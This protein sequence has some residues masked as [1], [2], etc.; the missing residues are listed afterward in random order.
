MVSDWKDLEMKITNE[1][2]KDLADAE[3]K[4]ID[5]MAENS[6]VQ[7]RHKRMRDSHHI[8]V[9]TWS[10]RCAGFNYSPYHICS[11]LIRLYGK[12]HPLKGN[13]VRQHAPP[14]LWIADQH[15]ETQR[16]HH[17]PSDG[18]RQVEQP[19]TLTQLGINPADLWND[20]ERT[21][22]NEYSRLE[23]KKR[24]YQE[25]AAVVRNIADYMEDEV[26]HGGERLRRLPPPNLNGLKQLMRLM[27]NARVLDRCRK[28]CKTW[29]TERVG[30]NQF[31][32]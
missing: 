19:A 31:R 6:P 3:A 2:D 22:E 15:D 28:R 11:H 7:Q 18:P 17:I 14:L 30:G 32:G 4:S 8:N 10:C 21:D 24:K 29:G 23:E 12:P 5:P 1:D 9:H 25:F 16:F 26:E 13:S 27:G 20:T